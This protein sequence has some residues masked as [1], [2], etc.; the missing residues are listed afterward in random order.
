MSDCNNFCFFSL[1]KIKNKIKF[2]IKCNIYQLKVLLILA[3]NFSVYSIDQV[4]KMQIFRTHAST[5]RNEMP[6]YF[7]IFFYIN[8]GWHLTQWVLMHANSS[9]SVNKK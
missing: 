4:R 5:S 6:F 7:D 2:N 8:T 9:G 3:Y 1:N